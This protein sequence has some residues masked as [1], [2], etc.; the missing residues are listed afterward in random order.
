MNRKV[1]SFSLIELLVVMLLSTII[2][3]IIYFSYYN[4]A[5]Y[6]LDLTNRFTRLNDF[7]TL[8][9][10]LKTDFDRGKTINVEN[11]NSIRIQV[12]KRGMSVLYEFN[13]GYVVRRQ[14]AGLDTFKCPVEIPDFLMQ[15][16]PL[17]EI[18]G[19]ADELHMHVSDSA[20]S[21]IVSIRKR[22]DAASLL[23]TVKYDTL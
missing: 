12:P 23:E 22:Y 9:F 5:R 3:G 8:Y 2:V 6:Q 18:P 7:S 13:T 11:E 14:G 15:G 19:W 10:L 4:V 1:A 21:V 17:K 16:K 20:S